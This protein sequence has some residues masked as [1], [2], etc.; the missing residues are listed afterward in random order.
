MRC[1]IRTLQEPG[2]LAV[3]RRWLS[4]LAMCGVCALA[5]CIPIP[6]PAPA[7]MPVHSKDE[8]DSIRVG[9]S[10]RE[11]VR[12]V[13]AKPDMA[14]AQNTFWVY[15]WSQGH[16]KMFVIPLLPLVAGDV[17]PVWKDRYTLFLE[18]DTAGKLISREWGAALKNSDSAMCTSSGLCI[19]HPVPIGTMD[20]GEIVVG[21]RDCCSALTL[22]SPAKERYSG[23]ISA[24]D[25]TACL[26]H[27]YIKPLKDSWLYEDIR[28]AAVVVD[29]K[30]YGWIPRAAYADIRL[31]GGQHRIDAWYSSQQF[32]T[33]TGARHG[34]FGCA[35]NT[36]SYIR[37]EGRHSDPAVVVS[38]IPAAEGQMEIQ[39]RALVVFP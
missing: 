2:M 6:L 34:M 14:R 25:P 33:R 36:E 21:T 23:K 39:Q 28:G 29:D 37:V 20:S 8:L 30:S 22:G 4:P 38:Q 10:D 18:F 9:A 11:H 24:G 12:R 19:E 26:V 1:I 15:D 16:G 7:V 13:L 27:L 17:G 35:A 5:A 31:A 3:F 32:Q